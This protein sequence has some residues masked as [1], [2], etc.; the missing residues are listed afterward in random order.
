MWNNKPS[1]KKMREIITFD[2]KVNIFLLL[3]G[4]RLV[5]DKLKCVQQTGSSAT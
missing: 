3:P 2:Q 4:S 5:I 1:R